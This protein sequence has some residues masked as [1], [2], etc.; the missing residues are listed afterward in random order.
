MVLVIDHPYV[1]I[2]TVAKGSEDKWRDEVSEFLEIP[3]RVA[4]SEEDIRHAPRPLYCIH[5][6]LDHQLLLTLLICCT[7]ADVLFVD[8]LMEGCGISSSNSSSS[9]SNGAWC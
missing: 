2:A 8:V 4:M 6:G 1:L 7:G 3:L 5:F 9:N